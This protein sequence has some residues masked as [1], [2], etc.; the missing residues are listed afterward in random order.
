MEDASSVLDIVIDASVV[1]AWLLPL[2]TLQDKAN[3][4]VE[5]YEQ[6]RIDVRCPA[7]IAYE[8]LNGLRSAILSKRIKGNQLDEAY[9]RYYALGIPID[10]SFTPNDETLHMAMHYNLSLYDASYIHFAGQQKRVLYTAD[11]KFMNKLEA[12]KLPIVYLG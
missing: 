10:D 8:V 5:R 9:T 7:I 2:E 6:Q 11:R 4:L 3:A 1:L 12:T